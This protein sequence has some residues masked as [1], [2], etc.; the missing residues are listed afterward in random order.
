MNPHILL[1]IRRWDWLLAGAVFLL[2][3]FGLLSLYSLSGVSSFPF[4]WRQVVWVVVGIA[5][6]AAAGTVDFR[7]F[8]TQTFA[9]LF[10]YLLSVGLLGLVLVVSQRI[11]GIEAWLSVGGVLIQPVEIAKLA[12][13][14]LLAKFFSRRHT[15]IYRLRHLAVSGF[16]A[17][18]P[19]FL[20][21]LQPDLGSAA[22][23]GS[24]W[25]AIIAFS[26][27]KA[28]H[29]FLLVILAAVLGGI[30]WEGALEPYQKT[31]ILSFLYP[32]SDPQGAAYQMIQSMIAVGSG[33][34]WGKGLGF[35]SQSHLHFLPEAESDFIFAAFAEEWGFV[36][37]GLLLFLITFVLWRI[38]RIGQRSADNFS[39]LYTV[40][41]A[42]LIFVQSFIHI[43][44]NMGVLP[45][46]G[47]TLP[48][49]SYGGSSLITLMAGV[50]IVE[51]I[52][53]NARRA[54]ASDE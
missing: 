17:A 15:E 2:I 47:I 28:R 6:L 4:F 24:V 26:G 5:V 48:F 39:R 9:V 33:R 41:F 14:V 21:L 13:I 37:T 32:A 53:V 20:V 22:I 50:G 16:Y 3:F 18:A 38:I 51:S 54:L 10:F 34:V 11:R 42:T 27:I 44:A 7:L 1:R 46:T 29:I 8:R 23:L 25:I 35:G 43:G 19:A 36:G 52:R 12:L 45:I 30:A 49:V 40:G 31:R